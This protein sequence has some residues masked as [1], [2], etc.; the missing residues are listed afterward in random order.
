MY[1]YLR[2]TSQRQDQISERRRER[3]KKT[4]KDVALLLVRMELRIGG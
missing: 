3:G 2:R 1:G 4:Q